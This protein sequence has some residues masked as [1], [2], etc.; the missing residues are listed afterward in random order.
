M[1]TEVAV[2]ERPL[3][4][5]DALKVREELA[6]V[7]PKAL[8]PKEKGENPQLVAQARDYTKR[9]L[10]LDP[11]DVRARA[12]TKTAVERAG[13]NLS[14]ESL[15]MS[16]MLHEP[17]RTLAQR[18]ENGGP[19]ANALV[20]LKE[21]VEGLDPHKW[22]FTPRWFWPLGRKLTRYFTQYQ[23]AESVIADI[24]VSLEKGRAQLERDNGILLDDQAEARALTLK[25]EQ[26]VRL[27]MLI[28]QELSAKLGTEIPQDDER[29]QFVEQELLFTVRKRTMDV[30]QEL[31]VRQQEVLALEIIM[32]NNRELVRGVDRAERVTISALQVAVVVSFALTHQRIVL[33]KIEAINRTTSNLIAENAELLKTQGT[34]IHKQAAGAM[35][36]MDKLKAAFRDIHQAMDD[37]AR[38]RSEALPKMA[39]TIQELDQLTIE[40]EE[41]IARMER[42]DKMRPRLAIE[43][44]EAV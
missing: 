27:L 23:A 33:E 25:L 4:V 3:V 43:A 34:A 38:Y 22:D 13:A 30:Q 36:D 24:V 41:K 19:V 17:I 29:Y 12:D 44:G 26:L 1:A 42:G 39:Q 14:R 7:D 8:R 10:E 40:A 5:P 35:L 37:I 11:K 21:T 15:K 20:D 2:A 31:A 9:L 18:G 6:L 32:R 28:D 16:R